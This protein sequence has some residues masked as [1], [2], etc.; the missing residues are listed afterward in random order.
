MIK[1]L[2]IKLMK[3]AHEEVEDEEWK[4]RRRGTRSLGE[5]PARA[6]LKTLG[7][8]YRNSPRDRRRSEDCSSVWAEGT[9]N[10]QAYPGQCG[11]LPLARTRIPSYLGTRTKSLKVNYSQLLSWESPSAKQRRRTGH[12]E[13]ER[14]EYP[15]AHGT[16]QLMHASHQRR[17]RPGARPQPQPNH[18][19]LQE[20][21]Q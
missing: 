19:S 5:F 15:T 11:G 21:S 3:N 8:A 10:N 17:A 7:R 12:S 9:P 13:V 18:S 1:D 20:C 14:V 2:I 16:G 6:P 4:H